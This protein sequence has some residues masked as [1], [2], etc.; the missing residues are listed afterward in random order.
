MIHKLLLQRTNGVK[1]K[2]LKD[3]VTLEVSQMQEE[4]SNVFTMIK[5]VI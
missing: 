4:K 1:A 3:V 2:V 5:R